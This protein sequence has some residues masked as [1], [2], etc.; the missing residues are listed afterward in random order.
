MKIV[1]VSM[2]KYKM[3]LGWKY[4][5][6]N[7]VSFKKY[8][9]GK[10]WQFRIMCEYGFDLDFRKGTIIDNLL[11]NSAK[12]IFSSAQLFKYL[13]NYTEINGYDIDAKI[14]LRSEYF[15][16]EGMESKLGI[17]HKGEY[18]GHLDPNQLIW[19]IAFLG[20]ISDQP[21]TLIFDDHVTITEAIIA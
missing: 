16:I 17:M 3:R 11:T 8:W 14:I 9:N 18:E 1:F 20:S 15:Y 5:L 10:I 6:K 2:R 19:L 21:I 7:F 13:R 4:R 12:A